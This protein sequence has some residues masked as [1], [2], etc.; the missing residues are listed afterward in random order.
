[1]IF[2]KFHS[3]NFKFVASCQ[4]KMLFIE[5]SMTNEFLISLF[6]YYLYSYLGKFYVNRYLSSTKSKLHHHPKY[7]ISTVEWTSVYSNVGTSICRTIVLLHCI[8]CKLR[9]GCWKQPFKQELMIWTKGSVT[10]KQT[11]HLI[12][13]IGYYMIGK[14]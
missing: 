2:G 9:T 3:M 13:L 7:V 4:Q 8:S 1:M 11:V 10:L 5:C 12:I 14:V 6:Y